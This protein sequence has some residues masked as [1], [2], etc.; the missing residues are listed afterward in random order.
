MP[1]F[2]RLLICLVVATPL[3][4]IHYG[5]I[6][7]QKLSYQFDSC[8]AISFV[9]TA[10]L[11]VLL[12]GCERKNCLARFS[13]RRKRSSSGKELGTVKWFNGGKGFGFITRQSGEEIF[14]HF[15][16][17]EKNSR[18]LAPGLDVEFIVVEGDKGPEA[19]EVAVV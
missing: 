19:S 1:L 12:T 8:T 4:A 14:V 2:Y 3:S 11:C 10:I 16:S 13:L 18:R 6:M 15:R 17:V 5:W 7:N 9:I